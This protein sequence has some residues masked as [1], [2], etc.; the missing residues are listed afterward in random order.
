MNN[1]ITCYLYPKKK[2]IATIWWICF[3]YRCLPSY[4]CEINYKQDRMKI[5]MVW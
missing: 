5:Q 4:Y 1:Y 2:K 3:Q